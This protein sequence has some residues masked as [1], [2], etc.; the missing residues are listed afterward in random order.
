[1]NDSVPP[2][3]F[4]CD[5]SFPTSSFS[6]SYGISRRIDGD[7][8]EQK[9]LARFCHSAAIN[10]SSLVLM[11]QVH[12][13]KIYFVDSSF[14]QGEQGPSYIPGVDALICTQKDIT[15]G[16]LTADCVPIFMVEEKLRV[17]SAIHAG[18]AG[19]EQHIEKEVIKEF[20]RLDVAR[21]DIIVLIGPSIGPCC[22]PVN[23]AEILTLSLQEEGVS[24][25]F[26]RKI[27]TS[28]YVNTFFSYNKEKGMTGRMLSY[29]TINP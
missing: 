28:C 24:Q 11:N 13:K 12:G 25:I 7:M 26:T 27:C 6:L 19:V 3:L 22:Y 9:A 2:P 18:R 23:L 20:D 29:I 8:K 21:K 17:I 10:S 14:S 16:I 1:M 15:L 4:F 5:I